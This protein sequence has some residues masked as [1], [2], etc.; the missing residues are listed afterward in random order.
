MLWPRYGAGTTK[1]TDEQFQA[2]GD[3]LLTNTAR[4]FRSTA[5]ALG[6][7]IEGR[8]N[9]LDAFTGMLDKVREIPIGKVF[10]KVLNHTETTS[11]VESVSVDREGKA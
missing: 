1:M 2:A 6:V 8:T 5:R 3:A 11:C 7:E 10:D 9:I 4:A